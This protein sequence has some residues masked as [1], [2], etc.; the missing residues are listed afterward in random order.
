AAQRRTRRELG[1]GLA[2][3]QRA[4][5][6][7]PRQRPVH[8]PPPAGEPAGRTL[9][10]SG[11]KDPGFALAY[12]SLARLYTRQAYLGYLPADDAHEKAKAAAEF[13]LQMDD[14]LAAAH[15]ALAFVAYFYEWDWPS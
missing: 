2:A 6:E 3:A 14:G 1:G 9:P 11:S 15:A 12:A 13:A 7:D 10:S 5:V 4:S 8:P